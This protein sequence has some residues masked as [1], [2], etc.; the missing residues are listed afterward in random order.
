MIGDDY[1]DFI[2]QQKS[3]EDMRQNRLAKIEIVSGQ[4]LMQKKF[5]EPRYLWDS[6]LPDSGLAIMAASKAAGKTQ[7]LLQLADAISK[8]RVFLGMPTRLTKTLFIELELSPRR[9]QQRL[10]KMGIVANEY[11]HFAHT[12]TQGAEGLLTIADA[13]KENGYGLVIVDVM[14]L[15]WPMDADTNSYQ[16]VYSVLGPL[17]QLAND[18]GVMILLVTHRRKAETADYLDGVIGSVGIA[19]NADVIFTLIRTR[20][21]REAILYIDGNDIESKKLALRFNTDPLG[22]SLSDASP[23]EASL[24]PERREIV[25]T[26][27]HLGG[28]AKPGQVAA[29]LGKDRSNV[30]HLMQAMAEMGV[31]ELKRTGVY[32]LRNNIPTIPTV[33][34]LLEEGKTGNSG[35]TGNDD[36]HATH[37][38]GDNNDT[39][40]LENN[41]P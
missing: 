19:A 15:L 11:L 20:G 41:L 14:Q 18:L 1:E 36:G 39:P 17:R 37:L 31:L 22:F 16:D 26:I 8:G 23:V 30:G 28:T 5:P 9:T 32:A 6:V 33:P 34:T 3:K 40:E 10:L 29:M 13:V 35:N 38:F 27:R 24:T 12:W 4:E 21:E 25:D 2:E 7:A